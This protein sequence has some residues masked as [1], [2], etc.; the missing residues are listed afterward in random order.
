MLLH[1][2][3]HGSDP[4]QP[5]PTSALIRLQTPPATVFTHLV[6]MNHAYIVPLKPELPE[7]AASSAGALNW[8]SFG[9]PG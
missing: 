1:S 4:Q 6:G 5:A 2:G 7:K 3:Q 8:D 9:C